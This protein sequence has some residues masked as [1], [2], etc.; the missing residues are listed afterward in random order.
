MIDHLVSRF[1]PNF[2][3]QP[4]WRRQMLKSSWPKWSAAKQRMDVWKELSLREVVSCPVMSRYSVW[5]L[6]LVGGI[7]KSVFFMKCPEQGL[8]WWGLPGIGIGG[9]RAHRWDKL[10]RPDQTLGNPQRDLPP[11][12]WPH[13]RCHRSLF[14]SLPGEVQR[15]R[16]IIWN[17][18]Y[19]R[20]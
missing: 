13:G 11:S 6:G 5:V 8:T 9:N 14:I 16:G 17:P 10:C 1:I 3:P 7:I 20:N 12:A 4:W 18:L 15:P 2:W 19:E